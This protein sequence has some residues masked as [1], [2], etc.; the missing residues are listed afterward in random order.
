MARRCLV[1]VFR[2]AV[3]DVAQVVSGSGEQRADEGEGD[4]GADA[5]GG[6]RGGKRGEGEGVGAVIDVG[7]VAAGFDVV[8]AARLEVLAGEGGG[9]AEQADGNGRGCDAKQ[10]AADE[11]H[12]DGQPQRQ[13]QRVQGCA[14]DA[15]VLLFQDFLRVFAVHQRNRLMQAGTKMALASSSRPRARVKVVMAVSLMW[16]KVAQL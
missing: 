5:E 1:G 7:V 15:E 14:T 16:W 10:F 2:A 6:G 11:V 13:L 3:V 4:A 9:V 8:V 12:R